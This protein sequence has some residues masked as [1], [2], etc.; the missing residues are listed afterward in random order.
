MKTIRMSPP[1]PPPPEWDQKLILGNM[2]PNL[3]QV[4]EEWFIWR[5]ENEW[6]LIIFW[7]GCVLQ[8]EN[9]WGD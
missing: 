3:Y 9:N 8:E 2:N 4:P 5:R 6:E 7:P 1:P